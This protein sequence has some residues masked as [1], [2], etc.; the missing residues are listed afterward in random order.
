MC[1]YLSVC[2][3]D[4]RRDDFPG[5]RDWGFGIAPQVNLS[6]L[7]HFPEGW[8]A[9]T[10]TSGLCSCGFFEKPGALERQIEKFR[11][12]HQKPKYRKQGWTEGKINRAIE[13]LRN[14][15]R[16]SPS[17]L[18]RD[19]REFLAHFGA[20]IPGFSFYLHW[21]RGDTATESLPVLE[22]L[23]LSPQELLDRDID[24]EDRIVRLT[25]TGS[26]K[27]ESRP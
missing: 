27:R 15:P 10:V 13:D 7:S 24:C 25:P 4:A 22:T 5:V 26:T 20:T 1:H 9:Y 14:K 23:V 6:L 18:R 12:K 16:L 3:P 8:S 21:Y 17:G 11:E 19:V 2:L